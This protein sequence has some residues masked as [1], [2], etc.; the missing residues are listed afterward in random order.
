MSD[1]SFSEDLVMGAAKIGERIGLDER[2]AQHLLSGGRIPGAVRLGRTWCLRW[3]TFIEEFE[4]RE[5]ETLRRAENE[6]KKSS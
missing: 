4:R 1:Y 3:S 5:A 2:Q 6:P